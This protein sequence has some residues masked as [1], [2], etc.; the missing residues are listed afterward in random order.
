VRARAFLPLALV[1]AALPL[2][3]YLFVGSELFLED[4]RVPG[5]PG[6]AALTFD[7]GPDP[8]TTPGVLE[9]LAAASVTATFF[10]LGERVSRNRAL[11]QEIASAGHE[12]G[13]HGW[14]HRNA[15]F[16]RESTV[17]RGL[18]DTAGAVADAT[19]TRPAFYRPPYGLL[20]PSARRAAAA[21]G[22]RPH[23]WSVWGKDWKLRPPADIFAD[24]WGGLVPGTVILLHDG[25]GAGGQPGAVS[26]MRPALRQLLAQSTDAGYKLEPLG[27]LF[28]ER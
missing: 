27:A 25:E 21:A 17:R 23:L 12:I 1:P 5:C 28:A 14:A 18:L 13:V 3:R 19:G 6:R 10:V 2:A 26:N 9:D 16:Q 8:A 7:D 24:L 22:L 15:V 20:P 4:W 11:A